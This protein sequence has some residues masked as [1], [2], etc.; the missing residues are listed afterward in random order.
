MTVVSRRGVEVHPG[1]SLSGHSPILD[2]IQ[3][4]FCSF[5]IP[6]NVEKGWSGVHIQQQPDNKW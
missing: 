2:C 4:A 5:V 6:F 3:E 1:A